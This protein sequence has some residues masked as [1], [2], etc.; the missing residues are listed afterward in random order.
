MDYLYLKQLADRHKLSEPGSYERDV[1]RLELIRLIAGVVHRAI[2]QVYGQD[3]DVTG[4]IGEIL[5]AACPLGDPTKHEATGRR[6]TTP[7]K[8]DGYPKN[9]AVSEAGKEGS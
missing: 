7:K 1:I 9:T 8:D 5:H 3:T 6:R 2:F 4:G